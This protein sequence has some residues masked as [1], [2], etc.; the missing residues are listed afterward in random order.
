MEALPVSHPP[1]TRIQFLYGVT[2]P[3]KGRLLLPANQ[4]IVYAYVV[5]TWADGSRRQQVDLTKLDGKLNVEGPA[6]Y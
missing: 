4:Q 1:I 3:G 6:P 5:F 2:N